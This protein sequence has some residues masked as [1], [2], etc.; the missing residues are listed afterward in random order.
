MPPPDDSARDET[1]PKGAPMGQHP[2]EETRQVVINNA[3]FTPEDLR[4]LAKLSLESLRKVPGATGEDQQAPR[5]LVD[6]ETTDG[7]S[8]SGAPEGVFED[9]GLLERQPLRTVELSGSTPSGKVRVFLYHG[10]ESY[11]ES[12]IRVVGYDSIWVNGTVRRF[13]DYLATVERQ[14]QWSF[15]SRALVALIVAVP[16]AAGSV[17]LGVFTASLAPDRPPLESGPWTDSIPILAGIM[18]GIIGVMLAFI[19]ASVLLEEIREMWPRIELRTGKDYLRPE[20]R[21][22][23]ALRLTLG[24]AIVP[25]SLELLALL[26]GALVFD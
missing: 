21:K 23:Q 6:V 12:V 25:F 9:D 3:V 8:F 19:F 24:W 18:V 16:T 17:L 13:E 14:Q 4:N 1:P 26:V 11:R 7:S 5:L 10:T 2:I 20:A 15:F 22:R